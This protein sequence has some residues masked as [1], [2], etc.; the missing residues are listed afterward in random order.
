MPPNTPRK[1]PGRRPAR[2]GRR[3]VGATQPPPGATFQIPSANGF[4]ISFLQDTLTTSNN[5]GAATQPAAQFTFGSAVAATASTADTTPAQNIPG[6][7]ED[8]DTTLQVKGPAGLDVDGIVT[9]RNLNL[10]DEKLIPP[11]GV[12]TGSRNAAVTTTTPVQVQ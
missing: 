6:D 12:E 10:D 4:G 2:A 9:H 11:G 7:T 5:A 1:P 3:P 8:P